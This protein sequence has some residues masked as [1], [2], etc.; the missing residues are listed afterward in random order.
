MLEN[1]HLRSLFHEQ[2]LE[3][4][5]DWDTFVGGYL[6]LNSDETENKRWK[7]KMKKMLATKGYKNG[8]VENLG[9]TVDNHR[10]FL[11]RYSFLFQPPS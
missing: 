11:Q 2:F 10:E 8:A 6:Q 9:K 7:T 5:L 4:L 3:R 1:Q